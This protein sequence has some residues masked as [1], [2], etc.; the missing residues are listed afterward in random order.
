[1]KAAAAGGGDLGKDDDEDEEID[2]GAGAEEEEEEDDDPETRGKTIEEQLEELEKSDEAEI[3]QMRSG[4]KR[5]RFF[6]DSQ[7][8]LI[9]G[10]GGAGLDIAAVFISL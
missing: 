7:W 4:K 2:E 5:G 1:M 6:N 9:V 3:E 8:K 10:I